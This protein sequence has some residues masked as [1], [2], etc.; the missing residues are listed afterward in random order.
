[1]DDKESTDLATQANPTVVAQKHFSIN[2]T[3]DFEA[4]KLVGHVVSSA[5]IMKDVC[6]LCVVIYFVLVLF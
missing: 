2:L 5:Y 1:M 4:K 6:R 3:T